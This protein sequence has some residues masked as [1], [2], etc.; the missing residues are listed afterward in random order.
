MNSC[1]NDKFLNWE[2]GPETTLKAGE[3]V[4]FKVKVTAHH[5][6]HFMFRLCN[7]P[8]NSKMGVADQESCLNDHVLKRVKPEDLHSDCIADDSRE[9]C[10]PIDDANPGYWY[11]PPK[12]QS[13][14]TYE[15]SIVCRML[16]VIVAHCSGGG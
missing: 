4:K 14:T 6:G 1:G 8:L 10:Q 15:M 9:D 2:D 12:V 3:V 5:K 13:T 11:L 16:L 7:K